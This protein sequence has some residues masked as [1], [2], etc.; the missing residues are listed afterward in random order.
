MKGLDYFH[1]MN[2]L[3]EHRLVQYF[4]L[5]KGMEMFHN[6]SLN[7]FIHNDIKPANMMVDVNGNIFLIDYGIAA[8]V[9]DLKMGFRGTPYYLS[10]EKYIIKC[11]YEEDNWNYQAT[12]QKYPLV[13][14]K[15]EF[16]GLNMPEKLESQPA[17]D[18]WAMSISVIML[19]KK[20]ME[21]TDWV[22]KLL[23]QTLEVKDDVLSVLKQRFDLLNLLDEKVEFERDLKKILEIGLRLNY[24]ERN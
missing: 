4:K 8:F 24:E 14:E 19:E 12:K 18:I 20:L 15:Y 17:F 21:T 1:E 16:W 13:K 7:G 5:F 6:D 2:P 22:G 10:P 23:L 3:P 11:L 9:D